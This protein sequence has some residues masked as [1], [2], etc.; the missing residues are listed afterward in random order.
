VK[1]QFE[2]HILSEVIPFVTSHYR[3]R[4]ERDAHAILGLSGGG[5]GALS[6]AI[7]HRDYFSSVAVLSAPVNLLYGNC[8]ND[9]LEDFDPATYREKTVYDPDEV[10]G[11]FYFGLKKVKA[12]KYVEPIFGSDPND[13]AARIRATNPANLLYGTGLQPG[14]L[15]IYLH[16]AGRDGYN[17]DA[18]NQSFA[19]LAAQRGI[20]VT[21]ESDPTANHT[22]AYFRRNATP[23]FCWLGRHLPGPAD[24]R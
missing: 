13:V 5:Y 2:D 22:I 14:E 9:V 23:A 8:H 7:R 4:P 21:I 24:V 17:F 19:W 3:I 18:Q 10:I 11:R 15:A 16:Y 1:G 12:K 20:G 6:M